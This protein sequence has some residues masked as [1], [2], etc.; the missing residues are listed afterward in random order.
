M[1]K[2]LVLQFPG[3]GLLAICTVFVHIHILVGVAEQLPQ[4][5][6]LEVAG[7]GAACRIAQG[8][9]GVLAGILCHL[10]PDAAQHIL[11][12]VPVHAVEDSDELVAAVA[13]HKVLGWHGQTQ[14][15]GKGADVLVALVVAEVIVDG[16]QVVEVKDAERR[17]SVRRVGRVQELFAL[18]L[19]VQAG[20]LIE[21]DFALQ[22]AV[23]SRVP[24][25]LEDLITEQKQQPHDV[26]EDD[27]FQKVEGRGPLLGGDLGQVGGLVAGLEEM[28]ALGDDGCL[29]VAA[30]TDKDELVSQVV[31][32]AG[33]SGHLGLKIRVVQP[34]QVQLAA[35]EAEAVDVG[36]HIDEEIIFRR[37]GNFELDD[38]LG[39]AAHEAGVV[40]DPGRTL[41][42]AHQHEG[43]EK[44]AD[45]DGC[46]KDG[47]KLDDMPEPGRIILHDANS[48]HSA[49]NQSV[50]HYYNVFQRAL[51]VWKRLWEQAEL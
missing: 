18:V 32:F 35:A 17:V 24:Q 9:L 25:G 46:E 41:Y 2:L 26:R 31:E 39:L 29:G 45:Q 7:D 20:G 15:F 49:G 51:Q 23:H 14:L 11:C 13:A 12:A 28:L 5:A 4:G 42:L 43:S 48:I 50:P 34:H 40:D 44:Q 10:R 16:A 22:N 6:A 33:K 3:L 8:H 36:G 1:Q 19:V 30:L 47:E 38:A 21:V 27:F 37:A